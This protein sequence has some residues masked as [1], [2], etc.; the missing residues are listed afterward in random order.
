[1]RRSKRQSLIALPLLPSFTKKH[2]PIMVQRQL[3][4]SERDR[5]SIASALGVSSMA[6]TRALR[7]ET[8]SDTSQRIRQI[9][10]EHGGVVQVIARRIKCCSMMVISFVR[11]TRMV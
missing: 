1:M 10:K 2:K 8:N 11:T 7:Y 6:M 4:I 5:R 9:A 3:A